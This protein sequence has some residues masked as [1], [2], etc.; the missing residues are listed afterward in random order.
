MSDVT[1]ISRG[2][3]GPR[4]RPLLRTLLGDVLRRKR[5]EQRRTLADVAGQARISM[6]Y[7]SEVERG[8]KEASSEVLAAVCDALMV[9]LSDVLTEVG[10]ELTTEQTTA[11]VIRLDTARLEPTRLDT[12]RLDASR[13]HNAVARPPHRSGDVVLLAA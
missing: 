9:R 4:K 8:L 2:G 3:R 11:K 6:P 1:P 12:T 5:L 13:R 10:R 7:L